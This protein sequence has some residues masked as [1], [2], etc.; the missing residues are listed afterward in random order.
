MSFPFFHWVISSLI[1]LFNQPV[2]T[3]YLLLTSLVAQMVRRLSTM[4]EIRVQS[5]G[6]EDPLEKEMAIHSSTIAWKIPWT[7]EPGRLC[8]GVPNSQTWL[9]D[10]TYSLTYF[11]SG[12]M[13][14]VSNI[15]IHINIYIY[16][17]THINININNMETKT[18]TSP[19]GHNL[20]EY[21]LTWTK[22]EEYLILNIFPLH[23]FLNWFL[24]LHSKEMKG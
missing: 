2:F 19:R 9:S 3:E 5:L 13:L 18:K 12:I 4:C 1:Q 7:G 22:Y 14:P 15:Y 10:F 17:H 16:I 6:Q 24:C 8:H 23:Y 11:V 21:R 20:V